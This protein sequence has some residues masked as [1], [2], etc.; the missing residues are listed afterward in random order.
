MSSDQ[1][2]MKKLV[3]MPIFDVGPFFLKFEIQIENLFF[4]VEEKEFLKLESGE[5][6][7]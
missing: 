3:N 7:L 1:V 2:Y 4:A 5:F 6:T